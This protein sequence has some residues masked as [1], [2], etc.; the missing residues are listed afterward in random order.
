MVAR[1][2]QMVYFYSHYHSTYFVAASYVQIRDVTR[3]MCKKTVDC[4]F[5]H[6]CLFELFDTIV[7]QYK[8]ICL[9]QNVYDAMQVFS[10]AFI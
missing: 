4:F 5:L 8:H 6:P 2:L 10:Y 1:Q 3:E 9:T 7:R